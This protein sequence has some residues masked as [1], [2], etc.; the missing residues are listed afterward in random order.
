ML[1]GEESTNRPVGI[2]STIREV[3]DDSNLDANSTTLARR[4]KDGA[5]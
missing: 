1:I 4:C 2:T 5:S 3:F